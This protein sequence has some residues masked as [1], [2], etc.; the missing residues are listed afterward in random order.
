M[1]SGQCKRLWLGGIFDWVP[2]LTGLIE[3]GLLRADGDING[4]KRLIDVITFKLV[5]YSPFI[6]SSALNKPFSI[7][8]VKYGTWSK[9]APGERL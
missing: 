1:R 9:M 6:S 7:K 5:N 3:N 8:P 2:S 4:L